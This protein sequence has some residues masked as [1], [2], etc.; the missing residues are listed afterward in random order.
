MKPIKIIFA[1]VIF[2]FAA[3]SVGSVMTLADKISAGN[4]YIEYAFYAMIALLLLIFVVFP[5]IMYSFTPSVATLTLV[6]ERNERAVRRYRRHLLNTIDAEKKA[7]L[8]KIPAKDIEANCEFMLQHLRDVTMDKRKL[9]RN[10]AMKLTTTVIISPNSFI[11]GLAV[12][13]GNSHMI[14]QL[15]KGIGVRYSWKDII[16]FY[17]N[18]FTIA[19][20]TGIIQEFDEEIEEI[21]TSIAQEFSEFLGAESGRSITESVPFA[22]I[23]S[24]AMVPI[25]EAAGNYAYVVYNGNKFLSTVVNQLNEHP[26]K[27]SQV[28]RAARKLARREKYKYLAEM[29]AKIS[30]SGPSNIIKKVFTKKKKDAE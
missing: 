22:N 8:K 9:V 18:T 13:I 12:I 2:Y 27:Q 6:G 19:S 4:I 7:A 28:N 3:T 30:W 25:F 24:K 14:Y 10:T 17:F 15:S 20:V 11:D 26:L 23:L 1:F 21:I 5:L 29:T 16:N